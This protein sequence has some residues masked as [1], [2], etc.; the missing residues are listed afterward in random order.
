MAAESRIFKAEMNKWKAELESSRRIW[1]EE[2]MS[3]MAEMQSTQMLAI[4]AK[5][6]YAQAATD[7]DVYLKMYIDLK[8]EKG[9]RV[10]K[11]AKA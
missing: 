10:S 9:L 4:D 6:Q 2:R 5:V 7:R 1:S 8:N 3:I 11:K